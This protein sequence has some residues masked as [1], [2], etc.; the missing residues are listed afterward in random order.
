MYRWLDAHP[1]VGLA[2][3]KELR[4]FDGRTTHL[5]WDWYLSQFPEAE[6]IGEATPRY[7][8]DAD[9]ARI[10]ERL[11]DVRMVFLLREPVSRAYSD[12]CMH[13]ALGLDHRSFEESI[14]S[15][16]GWE[17]YVGTGE[18]LRHL[19]PFLELFEV[20]ALLTDDMRLQPGDAFCD[21]CRFLQVEPIVNERVGS[22]VNAGT[23]FRSLRV[24][25]VAQR[26][27]RLPARV[28]GRLNAKVVDHPPM[29]SETAQRLRAHF[30]PH[31]RDLADALGRHVPWA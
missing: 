20:H 8:T 13:R 9:P 10:A 15:S 27:P 11:P 5:G 3:G 30:A 18:Y 25:R 14:E 1:Q 12:Y 22:T 4:Y 6:V 17:R 19:G 21:V 16:W 26:L 2:R 29:D 24:R 31:N 28:V 7:L 23:G